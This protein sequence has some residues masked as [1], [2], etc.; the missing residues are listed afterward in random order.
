MLFDAVV[1]VFKKLADVHDLAFEFKHVVQDE[2][3]DHHEALLS[4]M[5]ISVVEKHK[6]LMNSFVKKVREPIEKVSE[7]NYDISLDPKLYIRLHK[8]K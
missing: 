1:G 6:D 7:S 5:D 3:G 8:A 4:D 2:M